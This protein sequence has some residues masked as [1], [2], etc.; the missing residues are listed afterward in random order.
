MMTRRGF[1][2][3]VLGLL[4]FAATAEAK[5]KRP[6]PRPKAKDFSLVDV[7]GAGCSKGATLARWARQRGIGSDAVMAVGD[8]LNDL[9][10]LKFAGTAVVMGNASADMKALGYRLTATNDECGLAAAVKICALDV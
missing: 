7:N 6:K 8:N 4:G 5:P 10:M 2:P 9:D 1:F 3:V